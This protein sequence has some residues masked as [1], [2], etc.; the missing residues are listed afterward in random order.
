MDS[1]FLCSPYS[2]IVPISLHLKTQRLT[3]Q[4]CML[5]IQNLFSF[6]RGLAFSLSLIG[7]SELDLR[8]SAGIVE[9]L[10]TLEKLKDFGGGQNATFHSEW[11][12]KA[13][14]SVKCY[15]LD[16]TF[17]HKGSCV[18]SPVQCIKV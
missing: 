1:S 4:C 5:E 9:T 8:S 15:G 17:S 7:D 12:I 13:R 14:V 3:S 6:D 18:W 2:V 11:I 10:E 16:M